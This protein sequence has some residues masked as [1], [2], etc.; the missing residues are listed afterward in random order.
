MRVNR[1]GFFGRIAGVV[2]AITLKSNGH[3]DNAKLGRY[4]Q[5]RADIV[6]VDEPPNLYLV[7]WDVE[8][9]PPRIFSFDGR[10]LP[11]PHQFTGLLESPRTFT[12]GRDSQ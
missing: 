7:T 8:G 12:Q 4:V 3:V 2:A 11:D 5:V 9:Q 1:R 10:T 6:R